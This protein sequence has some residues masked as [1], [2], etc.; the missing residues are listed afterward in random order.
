MKA[1]CPV[2]NV[3]GFMERRGSNARIKHYVGFEDGKRKYQYHTF[4]LEKLIP[5][6]SQVIPK[7]LWE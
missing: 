3:E 6:D 5:P 1:L 7:K 2:C 4:P